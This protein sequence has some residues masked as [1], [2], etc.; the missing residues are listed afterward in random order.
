MKE[1][2]RTTSQNNAYWL[3]QQMIADEMSYQDKNIN[4][5]L[6]V[7]VVAPTKNNLHEVFKAILWAKYQKDSTKGMTREEWSA[8][9]DDYMNALELS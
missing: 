5:L 9:L 4:N 8:C 7:I 6:E 3:F 1:S 2:T